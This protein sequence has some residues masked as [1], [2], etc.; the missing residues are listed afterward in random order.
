MAFAYTGVSFKTAST[1]E[2]NSDN[3][4][5]RIQEQNKK[6]IFHS[7]TRT[8]VYARGEYSILL[9]RLLF[10]IHGAETNTYVFVDG[11]DDDDNDTVTRYTW[12]TA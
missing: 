5:V 3:E 11:D 7:N 2:I 12:R 8:F 1:Q 4:Y 10:F 9:R 6:H